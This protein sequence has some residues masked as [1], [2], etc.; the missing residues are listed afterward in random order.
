MPLTGKDVEEIR[1]RLG[2]NQSEF[3]E[4]IGYERS[5]ISKME[6]QTTP[7]SKTVEAKF[8][9]RLG[10]EN[11]QFVTPA[12]PKAKT[13]LAGLTDVSNYKA[14][15]RDIF[16]EIIND[17]PKGNYESWLVEG[18]S[19]TPTFL[20]GDKLICKRVEVDDII[21]DR[22]YV[23]EIKNAELDDYRKSGVWCKR[24]KHRKNNGWITATSDNID[25]AEP[26][27][28]FR[29]KTSDVKRVWYP[30][31]RI[32]PDMSNPHRDIYARLDDL[33]S[34]IELLET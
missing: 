8:R 23:I 17:L 16:E 15:L 31:L 9:M 12:T 4:L 34:R 21:D 25:T 22:V 33:E 26:Y 11:S 1:L 30:Y 27:P 7:F 28:T 6:K 10:K 19:M 13:A 2:L 5:T 14:H 29:I 20:S 32:T 18:N 24:L 3:A